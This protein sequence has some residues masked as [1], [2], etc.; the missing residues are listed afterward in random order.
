ME[1]KKPNVVEQMISALEEQN[2][3]QAKIIENQRETI[4]LQGQQNRELAEMLDQILKLLRSG[5]R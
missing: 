3:M 1:K 4:A 5:D 2:E